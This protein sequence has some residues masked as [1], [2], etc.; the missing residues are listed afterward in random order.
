M[1]KSSDLKKRAKELGI[2][3]KKF[4]PKS[5]IKGNRKLTEYQARKLKKRINEI[6]A[7]SEFAI[8]PDRPDHWEQAGFKSNGTE[9]RHVTV[10]QDWKGRD[11]E[12]VSF[13]YSGGNIIYPLN[14]SLKITKLYKSED[15][16]SFYQA[17]F[18]N[19]EAVA[20]VVLLPVLQLADYLRKQIKIDDEQGKFYDR[21]ALREGDREVW[22]SAKGFEPMKE[23]AEELLAMLEQYRRQGS[24]IGLGDTFT[25]IQLCYINFPHGD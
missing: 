18:M 6:K 21:I 2:D 9:H 19:N 25:Y 15:E 22:G 7:I 20:N 11:V 3:I 14:T 5:K 10:W 1:S 16:L 24:S 23:S 4:F 8:K 17:R 13:W 12:R